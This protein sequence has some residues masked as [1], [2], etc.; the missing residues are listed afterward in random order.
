[1]LDSF[2]PLSKPRLRWSTALWK[3]ITGLL[4]LK[5]VLVYDTVY[6][7]EFEEAL[8]MIKADPGRFNLVISD[9]AMPEMPGDQLI[10]EIFAVN[11]E[12][13]EQ[14]RTGGEDKAGAGH[15]RINPAYHFFLFCRS[16]LSCLSCASM[17]RVA[18]GLAS[19]RFN[20]ISS[21]VSSQ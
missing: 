1:M 9:M 11:P 2:Y 5:A 10:A 21:P 3:I 15:L 14:I 17:H 8:E 12:T 20:P 4:P 19:S 16:T 13:P 7:T 18:T 6:T